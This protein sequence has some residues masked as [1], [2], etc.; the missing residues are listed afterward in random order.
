V[1]RRLATAE[2]ASPEALQL[3]EEFE[4]LRDRY[5]QAL[6]LLKGNS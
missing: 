4:T 2:P 6:K 3:M 5:A 1:D